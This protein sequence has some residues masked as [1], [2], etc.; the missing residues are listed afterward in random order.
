MGSK[1]AFVLTAAIA[2]IVVTAAGAGVIRGTP[3]NDMLR[4]TAKADVL[5]GGGGNDKLFGLAGNDLLNGGPGNDVLT[6]GPGADR[7]ACGPGRD[8]AVVDAR[9]SVAADCETVQGAPKPVVS[10]AGD[11]A[12]DLD[13]GND[14]AFEVT[15]SGPTPVRVTVAYA[16]A[17]GTATAGSDYTATAG[18]L[19]LA[20]GQTSK[21][22]SVPVIGD[23]DFEPDETFTL[24]LSNPVNATLGTAT[25]TATITNDDNAI[26]SPGH[27]NGTV[28]GSGNIDFDVTPD[29]RGVT[30][31]TLLFYMSCDNGGAGLFTITYGGT[32]PIRPDLTFDGGFS[33]TNSKDA[34][35]T[36]A[37]TGKFDTATNTASGTLQEHYTFA[38][39]VQ[40]DSGAESWTAPRQ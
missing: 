22:V 27:Y 36:V 34:S 37:L 15:L 17:N 24:T 2:A 39:G 10:V 31:F 16:T 11:E 32:K 35:Y 20:P 14:A 7:F 25:A 8:V 26:A 5:I 21:I 40:C 33:G 30:H 19:V 4:G 6:G 12:P 3:K 28:A 13:S 38:N 23:D 9:D 1:T 18:T 29:G